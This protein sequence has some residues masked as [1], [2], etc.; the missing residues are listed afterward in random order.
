M[1]LTKHLK[2]LDITKELIEEA[3]DRFGADGAAIGLA[4]MIRFRSDRKFAED[5][6]KNAFPK[7]DQEFIDDALFWIKKEKK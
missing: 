1:V 4:A 3:V 7:A 2:E 6:I 5:F